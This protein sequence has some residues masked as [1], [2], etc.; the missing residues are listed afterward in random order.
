M[1]PL[2]GRLNAITRLISVLLPDPL[3]PTRAVVVPAGAWKLTFFSTSTPGLYSKLTSSKRTSPTI[4]PTGD[5]VA[6]SWSS[7]AVCISSRI[8][9]SPAKASLI[10]GPI[11]ARLS[12]ADLSGGRRHLYDRRGE[13]S[14]QQDVVEELGDRRLLFQD[15]VPGD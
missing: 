6:S 15:R 2:S 4:S 13:Q 3:D 5:L 9:S 1:R 14:R 10:C 8:R 7:V 11:E 12:L